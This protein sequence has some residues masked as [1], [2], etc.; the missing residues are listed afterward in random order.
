MTFTFSHL[1]IT[2]KLLVIAQQ[3]WHWHHL[4]DQ[5]ENT[6]FV[7]IR[8]YP[9]KYC[10][11]YFVGIITLS[12]LIPD[13]FLAYSETCLIRML[14]ITKSFINKTKV[15]IMEI[16]VNLTCINTCLFWTQMLLQRRFGLGI[17]F[18]MLKHLTYIINKWLS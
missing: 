7:S 13:W 4:Q 17:G 9:S 12:T 3:T 14:N 8:F 6:D 16:F 5:V 1:E 18:I 2:V 15:P 10:S 11:V